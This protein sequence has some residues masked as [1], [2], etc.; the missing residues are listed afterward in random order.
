MKACI[1][2]PLDSLAEYRAE[3][4]DTVN[5]EKHKASLDTFLLRRNT[6]LAFSQNT[7]LAFSQ[8]TRLAFSQNTRLASIKLIEWT[9]L[10]GYVSR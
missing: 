1:S 5:R 8:N 3:S 6:R 7:R 10:A 2:T 4:R 9:Q